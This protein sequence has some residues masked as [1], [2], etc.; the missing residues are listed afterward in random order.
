MFRIYLDT[1]CYNRP[2]DNKTQIT[3]QLE[4]N[5]KLFIQNEI[6][7]NNHELVWSFILD[8]ENKLNPKKENKKNIQKW[9]IKEKNIVNKWRFENGLNLF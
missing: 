1:C 3:I 7:N 4:S 5:A 9:T 8:H 2:F 6:S